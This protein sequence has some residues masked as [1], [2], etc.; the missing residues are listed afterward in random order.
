[1]NFIKPT[2]IKVLGTV[3]VYLAGILHELINAGLFVLLFPN[4]LSELEN[5]FADVEKLIDIS[6]TSIVGISIFSMLVEITS[7]YLAICLIVFLLKKNK[8]SSR[9]G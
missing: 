7:L 6:N 4:F 9:A 1:M 2:K 8:F 5:E 3:I